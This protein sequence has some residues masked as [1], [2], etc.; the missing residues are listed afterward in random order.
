MKKTA[1][2]PRI[3]TR[4]DSFKVAL[5]PATALTTHWLI[6]CAG[7]H[8][9]AGELPVTSQAGGT[10]AAPTGTAPSMT[11]GSL[12]SRPSG[13]ATPPAA[14]SGGTPAAMSSS[15][16]S[17]ANSVTPPAAVSGG[18]AAPAGG[19]GSGAVAT[20][21]SPAAGAAK[22]GS[23]AQAGAGGAIVP[24][25]G[26]VMWAT[27]GTKSMQGNYPDPFAAGM[28]GTSCKLYPSQTLGPCYAQSPMMREDISD[29]LGGLPVRLSFLV[30]GKDGCTPIPNASVDIWHSGSQGIYSA[31]A[32][33][34]TCNPGKD[35]VKSQM[36]CRGVQ[37]TGESGR[38]NFNTVF[39]GWYMGRT[40]HVHFTVRLNG[41]EAVTSQLYLEDALVDE[42]LA[43]GDYKARGKRDTNNAKDGI[44]KSG[45]ATADQVIMSTAKRPDGVLHAW[46]VLA[47]G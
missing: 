22:G 14:A 40:I 5:L 27:G 32:T 13:S 37:V 45:G 25:T 19:A 23:P 41:K 42:I 7:D 31:Y 47:I 4:R 20:A 1:K 26:S 3:I 21:G 28:M 39:P 30:V 29:G 46:K 10:T 35:D 2:T 36:F 34:T 15:A 8:A 16:G 44:F 24:V 12:A 17:A 18:S 6:G 33:G 11:A 43:Q 38:V 9:D